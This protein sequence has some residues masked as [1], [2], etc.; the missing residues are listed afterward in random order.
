MDKKCQTSYLFFQKQY[1]QIIK[2]DFTDFSAPVG[3]GWGAAVGAL[4]L[5]ASCGPLAGVYNEAPVR[6]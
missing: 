2:A 5:L 6:A 3:A 4:A 1:H